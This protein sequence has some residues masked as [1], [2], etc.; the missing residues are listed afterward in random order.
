MTL[1]EEQHHEVD[2]HGVDMHPLMHGAEQ[3]DNTDPM[4]VDSGGRLAEHLE[5]HQHLLDLEHEAQRAGE[6]EYAAAAAKGLADGQ[7]EDHTGTAPFKKNSVPRM[8]AK[9]RGA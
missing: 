2:M 3:Q 7:H 8:K 9:K 6:A 5:E 4:D 1:G